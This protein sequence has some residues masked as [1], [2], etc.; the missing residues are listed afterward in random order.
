MEQFIPHSGEPETDRKARQAIENAL[1]AN[2]R[3]IALTQ[4]AVA[5]AGGAIANAIDANLVI[6]Q[7]Y[8][9]Y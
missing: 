8:W 6:Y 5:D 4:I 9:L 1:N 2:E 7:S 3:A